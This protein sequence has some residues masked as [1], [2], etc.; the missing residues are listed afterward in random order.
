MPLRALM[1]WI[2]TQLA[3]RSCIG[4]FTHG[5]SLGTRVSFMCCICTQAEIALADVNRAIGVRQNF[6]YIWKASRSASD[7]SFDRSFCESLSLGKHQRSVKLLRIDQLRYL[8][9]ACSSG[10]VD[11]GDLDALGNQNA[12][13]A[14]RVNSSGRG[15]EW[16]P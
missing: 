12:T 16:A 15:P 6:T 5:V 3:W 7:D 10:R 8:I 2:S 9:S 4:F 1:C 13:A 11:A 14:R